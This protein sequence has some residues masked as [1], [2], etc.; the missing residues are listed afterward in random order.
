MNS[1]AVKRLMAITIG[2]PKS[3][4]AR[5]ERS[6]IRAIMAAGKDNK[7]QANYLAME[8]DLSVDVCVGI[9]KVGKPHAP[10][11]ERFKH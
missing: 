8:T 7:A 11:A 6:R 3:E 9:L 4:A 10:I 5:S 2:N 1:E